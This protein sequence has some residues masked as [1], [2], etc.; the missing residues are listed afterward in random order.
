MKTAEGL[1][2]DARYGFADAPAID[3][4]IVPSGQHNM[5]SDLGNEADIVKGRSCPA[6]GAASGLPRRRAGTRFV[7]SFV[8]AIA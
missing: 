3:V 2:L 6:G 7:A 4:L 8:F 5:D 1:V